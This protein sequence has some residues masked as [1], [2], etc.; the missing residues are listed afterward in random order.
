MPTEPVGIIG[1]GGHAAVVIDAL[2]AAGGNC[3]FL[4]FDENESRQGV[5]RDDFSVLP[6]SSDL[7]TLP[8]CIHVAVGDN[9]TRS[10]LSEIVERSGRELTSVVHP[11][12]V[13]SP[14]A[15]ILGG[16]FVAA[17]AIVGPHAQLGRSVIVN[18]NAVVD[19]DCAVGESA[20]IAPG[21]VLG[22][23]AR[24]GSGSLVG[25]G[26]VV[27]PRLSV[28]NSTTIGAGA[29]VTSDVAPDAVVVGVPAVVRR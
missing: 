10:K 14:T 19:H 4:V 5:S 17:G 18:H 28:G 11:S 9:E 23:N 27:L 7:G 8:R 21:A 3:S 13:V 26:A 20:H 12:A 25:A 16:C 24:I 1:A 29:V 6:L 2:R 22:G 15:K